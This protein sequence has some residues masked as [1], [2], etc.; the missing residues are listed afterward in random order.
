MNS[1]WCCRRLRPCE[2]Q[3]PAARTGCRC[4]LCAIHPRRCIQPPTTARACAR[5]RPRKGCSCGRCRHQ[6]AWREANVHAVSALSQWQSRPALAVPRVR[7]CPPPDTCDTRSVRAGNSALVHAG[8]IAEMFECERE[9]EVVVLRNR[10]GFVRAAVQAGT[11][12]LPVYYFG[13]S[14]LLSF[15][16]RC[17][18][19]L[20]PAC[21]PSTAATQSHWRLHAAAQSR[22]SPLLTRVAAV[23]RPVSRDAHHLP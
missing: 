19:T 21:T 11:P 4:A 23:G 18:S 6:R 10:R 7:R 13:N 5:R 16:P 20:P 2:L 3:V 9:R 12:L 22:G 8:G 17:G 1:R 15:G 14:Q